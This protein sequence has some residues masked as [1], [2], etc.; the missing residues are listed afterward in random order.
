VGERGVWNEIWAKSDLPQWDDLSEEIL[1]ALI[2]ESGKLTGKKVL[3]AGAGSGRISAR[4]ALQGAFVY[5]VDYSPEA[6]ELERRAFQALGV[7]GHFHQGDIRNLPYGD[8]FFDI[9]WSSGVLEH[10]DYGEQLAILNELVRV[11]KPGGL[12]ISIVPY[13]CSPFYILGKWWAEKSGTW[14]YGRESPMIT[15]ARHAA[16]LGAQIVNEYTIA[17]ATSVDFLNYVPGS[18][19]FLRTV[20]LSLALNPDLKSS[21]PGYLLLSTLKVCKPGHDKGIVHLSEEVQT[22]GVQS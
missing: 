13:A 7:R 16:D 5:L 9:S 14:P 3:E 12:I 10:Y 20:R 6:I 21:I 2:R 17:S 11:T 8:D 1:Q 18:E 22:K 15:F 4:L 19:D